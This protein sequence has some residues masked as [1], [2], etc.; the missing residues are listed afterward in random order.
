MTIQE[1]IQCAPAGVNA[2]LAQRR[3]NFF[4][5]GIRPLA[6]NRQYPLLMLLQRRCAPATRLCLRTALVVS[7]AYSLWAC[8]VLKKRSSRKYAC[9]A[10]HRRGWDGPANSRNIPARDIFRIGG[11]LHAIKLHAVD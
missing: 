7:G 9:V 2:L 4:Q 8:V 5:G 11:R 1:T 6:D 10:E 3:Q